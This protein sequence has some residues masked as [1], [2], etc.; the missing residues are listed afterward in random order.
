MRDEISLLRW[1]PHHLG[2]YCA[3]REVPEVELF[4]PLVFVWV[5]C[6]SRQQYYCNSYL[7]P[8]VTLLPC[9]HDGYGRRQTLTL[10]MCVSSM[11]SIVS[12]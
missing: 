9:H 7:V 3:D 5:V 4:I 10:F 1:D 6:V 12:M 2:L 11:F 8:L